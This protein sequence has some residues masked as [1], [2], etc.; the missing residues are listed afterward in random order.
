MGFDLETL[1]DAVTRHGRVAR[2]VVTATT[3]STPRDAGTSMLVWA[4]GQA[5]TIGG[6]TLEFQAVAAARRLLKKPGDWMR[7]VA[8][9]PLGPALGQCCGGGVQLLTECFGVSECSAIASGA[10]SGQVFA[11]PLKSGADLGTEVPKP[12]TVYAKKA[13]CL[14]G[15]WFIEGV[16]APGTPLWLYGAGH[17]GRAITTILPPLGFDITWVD[18]APDR[19]PTEAPAG[20]TPLI[21]ANPGEVVKYAP[22]DAV[23]LVLTY[24]HAL[25]LELC[26][27]ILSHAFGFAGLIGSAT[28][29]ARFRKRL[30]QLGHSPAQIGRITCP[31]GLPELGKSPESI[32]VGVAT[33]LLSL[34]TRTLS[35]PQTSKEFAQ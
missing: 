33:Q 2:I 4:D 1:S 14:T 16:T 9:V 29:W 13:P 19:F 31:I 30:E 23:H 24:S 28:K 10:N 6:G 35:R 7:D 5:G 34:R 26:H 8:S 21:A 32:A 18:T 17:V 25:D 12:A 20:V 22:V 11:R 3:G 15:G 27:Q